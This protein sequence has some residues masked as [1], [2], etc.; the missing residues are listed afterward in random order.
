MYNENGK[1]VDSSRNILEEIATKTRTRVEEYKKTVS[2]EE[3]KN[4][5]LAIINKEDF[6]FEKALKED[7]VH[8]ICEVK[9]ASPSKGVIAENF[10]Y[11]DIAKEYESVGAT[12]ISCLTEP[13]YF[14]GQDTYLEEIT[15][16]VSI[17]VLRKDFFVD[18]YMV[19]QAKVLGASAILLICALLS[20]EE[21]KE[22]FAIAEELGLSAIFE[23][24]T[25][26]EVKR[27]LSCGA[28]V[29]GVNNRNLKTFQ[30]DLNHS[31]ELYKSVPNDIIFIAE[32]GIKTKR[33]MEKL[34]NNN[35][36]SVLIGE[37]L[38]RAEN[39]KEML[40]NLRPCGSAPNPAIF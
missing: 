10:P 15:N 14:L 36:R 30:V 20:D 4:K 23:A 11:L 18:P 32:S 35:I 5:A 29:I 8:F 31:I 34:F 17:P 24:H 7:G 19:Y 2:L 12:A 33:D 28:R 9:K 21:L 3:M 37:T 13:Y 38:M 22:Y 25:L 6:V 39:K 40:D 27:A 26:D 16:T 1:K